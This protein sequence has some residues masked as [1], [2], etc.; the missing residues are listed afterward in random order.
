M[1]TAMRGGAA[2]VSEEDCDADDCREALPFV[3]FIRP[4]IQAHAAP[5]LFSADYPR[6]IS[7]HEAPRGV[8]NQTGESCHAK[9]CN[10]KGDP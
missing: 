3:F 4:N 1:A 6:I 2:A 7:T 9:I 8:R 5:W 10:R